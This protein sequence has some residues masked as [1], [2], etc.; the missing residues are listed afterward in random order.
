MNRPNHSSPLADSSPLSA[1]NHNANRSGDL[2]DMDQDQDPG[3]SPTVAVQTR[4]RAQYKSSSSRPPRVPPLVLGF[5]RRASGGADLGAGAAMGDDGD[6]SQ[7][8]FLRTRLK[9]RC[10]ERA[11]KARER[12][13][14]RKRGGQM[15]MSSSDGF[16]FDEEMDDEEEDPLLDELF[17]R[18]M[19]N[20]TRK[21]RRSYLHAY[22]REIGS[23]DPALEDPLEWEDEL[24]NTFDPLTSIPSAVDEDEALQDYLAAEALADFA[25]I[26]PEELFGDAEND[27]DEDTM[28]VS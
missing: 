15:N 6:G 21:T 12:A 4:R 3:S 14:N 27:W 16:D 18:I 20:Q 9:K 24:G 8:A 1:Y 7:A 11:T 5:P 2:F 28:D 25:D 22:D 10:L 23:S 13:V 17:I 26:P 19:R